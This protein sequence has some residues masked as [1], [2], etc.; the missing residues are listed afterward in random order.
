VELNVLVDE[1][2]IVTDAQ[3]VMGAGGKAG[4]NE[5]AIESVKKRRY[6][7]ATRDGVPVKVWL[8]VRIK[9]VLPK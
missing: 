3:I 4:L 8:P 7:P 2:G 6:R 5:A 9:F 1:R